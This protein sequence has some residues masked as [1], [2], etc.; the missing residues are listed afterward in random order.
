MQ[1]K[2]VFIFKGHKWEQETGTAKFYYQ[3]QHGREVFDF[4]EELEFRVEGIRGGAEGEG[5]EETREKTRIAHALLQ[6]ALD[7]ALLALG[8]SYYKLFCPRNIVLETVT[9]TRGQA[10]FWNTVYAKGLGEFFYKNK[11]DFRGV[12]Q[13][14]YQERN[15]RGERVGVEGLRGSKSG[16]IGNERSLVGIGGGKD[17]I[18]AGELLRAHGKPFTAFVVRAHPIRDHIV[19]ELGVDTITVERTFDPMLF[20]LNKR[21]DVFNGHVPVSSHYAFIGLFAALLFGYRY[22]IVGNERSANYGNVRYLEEEMN[23]Q[24]SKSLEF[25]QLFQDYAR[26]YITSDVEYFSL[27]RPYSELAI[28]KQ[29][30]RYPQYFHL[31]SSCNRNFKITG[32]KMDKLW[33]G[34]CPKCAFTFALLAAFLPKTQVVGIF[35]DN[36]FAKASFL[37]T[38]KELLGVAAMKPFDCVGTPDEVKVAFHLIM[39]RGEYKEDVI[40]DFFEKTV[41]PKIVTFEKMKEEV[42]AISQQHCIP[43]DF[44]GIK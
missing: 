5:Q 16:E 1:L 37:Q 11:I 23:H 10:A 30:C 29:F 35:G 18:V 40:M 32:E 13:F 21:Q 22:V 3:I 17:S 34:E 27:L 12:V 9:L 14:P 41:L 44:K 38:Y 4:V 8:V 36:L 28:T 39:E 20:A 33:C 24:W 31:F 7:N 6:T 26:R 15:G 42:F 43:E 19:R 2:D 25:E